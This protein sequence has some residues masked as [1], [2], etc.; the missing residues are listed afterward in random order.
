MDGAVEQIL[1]AK[2]QGLRNPRPG[3]VKEGEE[4][5]ITLA[6]M[7]FGIGGGQHGFN[8]FSGHESK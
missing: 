5:S 3:V 8:L 2:L 6:R 1:G 7:S 4:Q